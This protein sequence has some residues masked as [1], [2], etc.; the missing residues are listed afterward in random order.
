MFLWT[1]AAY[2]LVAMA[3]LLASTAATVLQPL[4]AARRALYAEQPPVSILTPVKALEDNF[5]GA[6]ETIFLQEYPSFEVIASALDPE[7]P[8][9]RL[10]RRIIA[11]HPERPTRF[12][13]TSAGGAVSPKVDNLAAPIMQASNDVIFTK[14]ANVVL[15]PGDLSA[16][17]RQ[18][19]PEVG[20]VC[21][22]PYAA[23]PENFAA[24]VEASILNGP[25]AR[26]LYLTS[27][28]GQGYGVG[29]IMLFRRS[30]FQRAGGVAAISH[31][32]GEDNAMARAMARIGLRTVFSHRPVRQELGR[33]SWG[34]VFQRQLRWSVIRRDELLISFLL[35]P[36][37]QAIP[38]FFAAYAAAPLVGAPPLL[39]VLVTCSAWL[40]AETLLSFI[41]GWRLSWAK[42]AIFLAREA[43]MIIVWLRAWTASRVVWANALI[44]ARK[45]ASP[46][47]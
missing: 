29:K 16:H 10:M 18:L 26:I 42:P 36:L 3:L 8:A 19:T 21:A 9:S 23:D 35:E 37:S 34:T 43:L 41:K 14:D 30:V 39:A 17:M 25:H 32:V 33:R 24:H 15:L 1:C 47:R 45:G 5:E 44:D 40:A 11:R 27:C 2:W 38:G 12:L 13:Q 28:L 22:I 31:T 20:L 4:I 46:A 7:A 6:Q